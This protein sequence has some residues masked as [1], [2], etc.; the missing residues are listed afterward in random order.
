MFWQRKGTVLRLAGPGLLGLA[1]VAL[2]GCGGGK[3]TVS[4]KVALGDG[5][6]VSAG[7]ITFWAGENRSAQATL[8]PDGTYSMGDAPVGE[9]KVTVE[10][11]RPKAGPTGMGPAPPG[12][13][14]M[15]PEMVPEEDKGLPGNVKIVPVPDKYRDK[16]STPLTYTVSRGAQ[17][18]D[19]TITP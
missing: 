3:A 16:S 17:Q 2:G 6:P 4:G 7:T 13:K 19:F 10:T 8:K 1:L 15:P 9:V 11:P 5:T 14:G 12:V 18:K